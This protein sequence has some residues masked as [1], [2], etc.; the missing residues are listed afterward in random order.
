MTDRRLN[1]L[2]FAF[3]GFA[4]TFAKAEFVWRDLSE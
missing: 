2:Y 1:D 4:F 3:T